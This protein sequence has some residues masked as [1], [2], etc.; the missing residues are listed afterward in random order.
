MAKI[1]VKIAGGDT[2]SGIIKRELSVSA[3]KSGKLAT[4]GAKMAGLAVYGLETW[5]ATFG[6]TGDQV[7]GELKQRAKIHSCDALQFV[8]IVEGKWV[9]ADYDEKAGKFTSF[10]IL[11]KKPEDDVPEL[12][13]EAPPA[14]VVG[15]ASEE[16]KPPAEP[17]P[18]VVGK[19]VLT[20][21]EF[22]A[23]MDAE[24]ERTTSARTAAREEVL[25]AEA[26]AALA[27]SDVPPLPPKRRVIVPGET[28]QTLQIEGDHAGDETREKRVAEI[29]TGVDDALAI[30]DDDAP[31]VGP[32]GNYV[33]DHSTSAES[34][35]TRG[36][37]AVSETISV[38]VGGESSKAF[39]V[40]FD[41]DKVEI[42]LGTD[43]DSQDVAAFLVHV[44]KQF[45]TPEFAQ[46]AAEMIAERGLS[47]AKLPVRITIDIKGKKAFIAFNP[48]KTFEGQTSSGG[49]VT[50]QEIAQMV[51]GAFNRMIDIFIPENILAKWT[52]TEPTAED[53]T[54]F[55]MVQRRDRYGF[56][57]VV[58]ITADKS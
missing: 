30:L 54:G 17:T 39:E 1:M 53:A 21:Q 10:Q 43:A 44:Q 52:G 33:D 31:A 25:A 49:K 38:S 18:P 34:L 16:I 48:K 19:P 6:K 9:V 5:A 7:C 27:E 4:A 50:D 36:G 46:A 57:T 55:K 28:S 29:L 22:D 42:D 58:T 24:N 14:P 23:D 26:E 12:P 56:S 32:G 8:K 3:A 47:S 37:E 35:K 2:L 11:D 15:S 40:A 51:I 20:D 45:M 41:L 13:V